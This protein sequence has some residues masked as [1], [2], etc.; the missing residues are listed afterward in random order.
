MSRLLEASG[1]A[2]ELLFSGDFELWLI[3][4]ISFKTSLL[5]MV[6]AT[7]PAIL[8]AFALAY[9]NFAGRRFLI[10]VFSTLLSAPAVVVA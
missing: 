4:G 1:H 3:V 10:T 2:L 9:G 5:A 6:F 7:P 8:A